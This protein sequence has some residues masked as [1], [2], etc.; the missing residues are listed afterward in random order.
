METFSEVFGDNINEA[1]KVV[2]EYY[3]WVGFQQIKIRI[4]RNLDNIFG[5]QLSHHYK[6]S[7]QMGP[8]ISSDNYRFINE[9][10]ALVGA[11]REMFLYYSPEDANA[12]W[13][14]DE[15]Y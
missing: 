6:G 5:Y 4:I 11:R 2:S 14:E 7:R 12:I 10:E 9:T 8:Y 13:E 3:A 15:D 1:Y